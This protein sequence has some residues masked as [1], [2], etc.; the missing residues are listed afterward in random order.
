MKDIVHPIGMSML[1]RMISR[2][3]LKETV[4]T[5]SVVS[6]IGQQHGQ[7]N[8]LNS[9]ANTVYGVGT[10]WTDSANVSVGDIIVLKDS[11]NELRSQAKIIKS[12]INN[13]VCLDVHRTGT[14]YHSLRQQSGYSHRQYGSGFGLPTDR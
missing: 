12:I 4:N 5:N 8:V 9:A 14:Y 13:G 10:T 6:T 3:E 11:D 7:I 1:S 2:S